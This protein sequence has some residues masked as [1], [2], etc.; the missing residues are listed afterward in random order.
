MLITGSTSTM[1]LRV[2]PETARSSLTVPGIGRR[3]LLPL[4]TTEAA[5]ARTCSK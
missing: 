5:R 4:T 3:S 2:D 1:N